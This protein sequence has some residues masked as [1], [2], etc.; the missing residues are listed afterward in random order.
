MDVSLVQKIA[1]GMAVTPVP[2]APDEVAGIANLK[3][4]VVTVLRVP[5]L[6][7]RKGSPERGPGA[8]NVL[9]FKAAA[10]G[11]DQ[12]GFAVDAPGELIEIDE[13]RTERL[14]GT[15]EARYIPRAFEFGGALCRIIDIDSVISR[16]REGG[17][18]RA[19]TAGRES[20]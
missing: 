14:E 13:G 8:A 2:S 16:F 12:M 17:G 3:G 1:R 15:E 5:A 10:C 20:R 4:M 7:G 19:V 18:R 9:V 11:G 6:L